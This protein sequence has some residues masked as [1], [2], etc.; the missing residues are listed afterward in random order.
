MKGKGRRREGRRE[1]RASHELAIAQELTWGA[2]DGG[3]ES[4]L[5]VSAVGHQS[6]EQGIARRTDVERR[7][8]AAVLADQRIARQLTVTHLH[9]Q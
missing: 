9:I 6:N 2:A 8:T 3:G 1:G 5:T 4:L 7:L